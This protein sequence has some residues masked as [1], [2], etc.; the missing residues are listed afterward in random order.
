MIEDAMY[1]F[2][3]E[4]VCLCSNPDRATGA[5]SYAKH[6]IRESA[7]K[8]TKRVY[9]LDSEN[10]KSFFGLEKKVVGLESGRNNGIRAHYN[11]RADPNLGVGIIAVR[12]IT[13]N[14]DGCMTRLARKWKC[15]T[16][17]E[18]QP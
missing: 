6:K 7:A 8:M 5:K 11:A 13:C 1:S 9:H 16:A 12:R 18:E 17:P 10:D 2:A 15:D 14:C 3:A 4:C